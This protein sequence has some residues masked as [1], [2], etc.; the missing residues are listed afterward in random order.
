M[1]TKQKQQIKLYKMSPILD[2]YVNFNLQQKDP[3]KVS[4][5]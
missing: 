2:L 1:I 5:F 3:C 4:K